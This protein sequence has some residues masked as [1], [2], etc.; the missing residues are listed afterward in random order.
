VDSLRLYFRLIGVRVRSQLQYRA[1]FLLDAFGAAFQTFI[2]FISLAFVLA[3]FG[4]IGGWALGEI[5]FLYG[6]AE[7]SFAI[8][9]MLFSG[10]DPG[11]FGQLVQRGTFDQFLLRPLGLPLQV[12][13]AE[14]V[15][16]RVGRIANGLLIL[17]LS[18]SLAS[19]Q[20]TPAKLL[21]LPVVM[22]SAVAF[23]GGLFVAGA[24]LCFWTVESIEVVNIFTY[25][26][27]T[28]M[29]YP[30]PIYHDILRKVF[31]YIV[32]AGLVI[33]YPALFFLDKPDPLG[34]PPFAPFLA[35]LAGFGTL[36]AAFALWR[37]GVRKYTSTGT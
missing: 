1:S 6:M 25:G 27:T 17:A 33:Y 7:T 31:L 2:E 28:M 34:L 22:F 36:A 5:A 16:R 24:T 35:P 4:A 20:W 37:I 18:L 8:M 29:S 14:I 12:F 23:F 15:V 32:P 26:G 11:F 3:R 9:D 13:T 19:I 30:L 21:Y 10:F